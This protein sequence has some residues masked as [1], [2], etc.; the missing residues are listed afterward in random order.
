MS[1]DKH[2]LKKAGRGGGSRSYGG[3]VKSTRSR[4]RRPS[5]NTDG[6]GLFLRRVTSPSTA[7]SSGGG[8]DMRGVKE[9]DGRYIDNGAHMLY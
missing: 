1:R 7:A 4:K 5:S 2:I 9:R 8:W 3:A 6:A